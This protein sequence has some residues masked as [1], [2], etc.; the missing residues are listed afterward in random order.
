MNASSPRLLP[1][2]A[3]WRA[4][5]A[6]AIGMAATSASAQN[7]YSFIDADKSA[8]NYSLAPHAPVASCAS[9]RQFTSMDVAITSAVDVPASATVPAYCKVLGV[10]APE[11]Q[12]EVRLPQAWNRRFYMNGSGG[13][14]GQPVETF[15]SAYR[16][17]A[18][19]LGFA[20]AHDNT[21]HDSRNEPGASFAFKNLQKRNDWAFRSVHLTQKVAKELIRAYYDRPQSYAYFDGC[22]NGGRQALISAQRYPGDFDGLVAGAPLLN[23]TDTSISYLWTSR[24]LKETPIPKAKMPMIAKAVLERCDAKDGLTDGLIADPRKCDFDPTRDLRRCTGAPGDDCFTQ[25]EI[26]TLAKIKAGPS[27][28]GKPLTHGVLPGAEP[29]GVIYL[30]PHN[31]NTG[32][33]EW[34]DDPRGPM[35]YQ[36]FLGEHFVRYMA[37]PNQDP[38]ASAAKFDFDKDPARMLEG[39]RVVDALNPDLSEFQRRGGKLLMYFGWADTGINPLTAI[40][41]YQEAATRN[42]GARSADFMRMFMMP[43]VFHCFGGYGP[44]RLD[45]LTAVVNWVERGTAPDSITVAKTETRNGGKVL[46]TRPLCPYPQ[47]AKYKGA[48]SID[49]AVNFSCAAP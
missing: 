19:K 29:Q 49:E 47:V 1:W 9:L 3:G 39:R 30:P 38:E 31:V 10:I 46:R 12:F 17:T 37:Y 6:L 22:S 36:S 11:I 33:F 48:G 26:D 14:G 43:G 45:A 27:S 28:N 41:Y 4:L 18:V 20:T 24:A 34:V 7:G 8:V 21:G 40:D 2:L 32:W 13:Y 23:F 44:D 35:F 25:G 15:Y 16:D 42:G 5:L